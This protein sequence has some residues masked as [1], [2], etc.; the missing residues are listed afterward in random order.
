MV[1]NC[2]WNFFA[3]FRQ[4]MHDL[5]PVLHDWILRGFYLVYCYVREDYL[6]HKGILL[7]IVLKGLKN[8]MVHFNSG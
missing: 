6:Y 7:R 8:L 3:L 4:I 5:M 2:L 1:L